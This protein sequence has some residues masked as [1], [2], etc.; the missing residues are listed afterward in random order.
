MELLR[1]NREERKRSTGH[2]AAH[3]GVEGEVEVLDEDLIVF[4]IG[5][6]GTRFL[7]GLELLR[8]DDIAFWARGEDDGL[9]C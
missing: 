1:D 2:P 7:D 4:E 9:V 3:G 5:F 8:G 6:C